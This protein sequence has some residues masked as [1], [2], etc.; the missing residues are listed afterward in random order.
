VLSANGTNPNSES[1]SGV[2]PA[3]DY[4]LVVT[5]FNLAKSAGGNTRACFTVTIQ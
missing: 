1:A 5:D 3:G 2:L 4:V